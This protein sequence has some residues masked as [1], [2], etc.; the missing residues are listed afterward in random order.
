MKRGMFLIFFEVIVMTF[1]IT[2][3]ITYDFIILQVIWSIGISMVLLGLVI[4]LPFYLI[5]VLGIIIVFCHNLLDFYEASHKG[6]YPL[7]YHL[8]HLPTNHPITSSHTL[9]V[10]YPFLPWTGVMILG[11][12]FGRYYL[13][14]IMNRQKRSILLGA[15]L[16]ILFIILRWTNIY[17]DMQHWST[18]KNP[19]YTLLSFIDTRKYPPSL[20]YLCMTIGPALII[21][22]LVDNVRNKLTDFVIVFGR[23][24]FFYYVL[25]FYL[26]HLVAMIIYLWNG[27]TFTEGVRG[28]QGFPIHF[29]VPGEAYSL[30]IVYIVWILIVLALYPLCKWYA[31]YKMTHNKWWLSYL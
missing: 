5:V 16:V 22:G 18:Q 11:Y 27:H 4:W 19:M 10:F 9:S 31:G 20:L 6:P 25:H 30:P 1:G 12:C 26:L 21:L 28:M 14:D 2:F 3:D 29:L 23:V 13:H 15:S 7:W 8:I 17:G 24:P